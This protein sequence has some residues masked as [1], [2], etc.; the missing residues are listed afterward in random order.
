MYRRSLALLWTGTIVFGVAATLD[1]FIDFMKNA[2]GALIGAT[3]MMFVSIFIYAGFHKLNETAIGNRRKS[4]Q[5]SDDVDH[6]SQQ[7]RDDVDKLRCQMDELGGTVGEAR[8]WAEVAA[9]MEDAKKKP[10][11]PEPEPDREPCPIYPLRL[12]DGGREAIVG[13]RTGDPVDTGEILTFLAANETG[14][15]PGRHS[16]S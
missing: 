4:E 12:R 9:M 3:A 6:K 7:L 13:R 15:L 2:Q 5:L 8:D 1:A 11:P 14:T 16:A 10:M